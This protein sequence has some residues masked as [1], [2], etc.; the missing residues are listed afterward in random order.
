M[1]LGTHHSGAWSPDFLCAIKVLLEPSSTHTPLTYTVHM[2]VMENA[3]RLTGR[4]IQAVMREWSQGGGGLGVR[5]T[6]RWGRGGRPSYLEIFQPQS[7]AALAWWGR[8]I[9][10]QGL[11]TG[12]GGGEGEGGQH[13]TQSSPW[14]FERP[15]FGLSP[16]RNVA[17]SGYPSGASAIYSNATGA[18]RPSGRAV[19]SGKRAALPGLRDTG[20]V[21][22]G[23]RTIKGIMPRKA[24]KGS[25]GR[26]SGCEALA[27]GQTT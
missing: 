19:T 3:D 21:K 16:S 22:A 9:K 11:V 15:D 20:S 26:E 8:E 25:P 24:W 23:A 14:A 6:G 5:T 4:R 17:P 1:T 27:C 2:P 18:L 13:F 7:S 10:V 12:Q